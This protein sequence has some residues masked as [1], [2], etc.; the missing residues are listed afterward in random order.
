MKSKKLQQ[1]ELFQKILA[2]ETEKA[3]NLFIKYKTKE[4]KR[5]KNSKK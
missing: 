4:Q 1:N 2:E 5:V 3:V